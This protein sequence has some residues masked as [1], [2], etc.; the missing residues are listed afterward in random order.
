MTQR[1]D[2]TVLEIR[3]G[4]RRMEFIDT[5]H[6]ERESGSDRAAVE[7]VRQEALAAGQRV[8]VPLGLRNG[9][10]RELVGAPEHVKTE[11]S[12]TGRTEHLYRLR[13]QISTI[14]A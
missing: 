6:G 12:G 7:F 9:Q 2:E 10:L 8:R 1:P 13:G 14:S 3:T 4:L 5:S 11:A